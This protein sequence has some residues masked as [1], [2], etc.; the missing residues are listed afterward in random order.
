MKISTYITLSLI[1]LTI[2]DDCSSK[3]ESDCKGD[4]KWTAGTAASCALATC[5]I[6]GSACKEGTTDCKFTAADDVAGTPAK[7]ASVA[8]SCALASENTAC[9]PV[10]G[11]K[12]TAA[13][14]GKCAAASTTDSGSGSGTSG[15]L[16]LKTSLFAIFLIFLF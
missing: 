2:C 11:C 9:D 15:A 14:A 16:G 4:C 7:C 3:S 1:I 6:E 13:V 12:F 10:A 5:T 8:A